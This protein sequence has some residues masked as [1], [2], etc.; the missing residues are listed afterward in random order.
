[1]N[2]SKLFLLPVVALSMTAC[3]DNSDEPKNENQLSDKEQTLKA[4]TA[5]YVDNTVLP[6]YK[7]MACL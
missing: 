7:A 2:L 4:A 6:T 1:M 5:A 3:S